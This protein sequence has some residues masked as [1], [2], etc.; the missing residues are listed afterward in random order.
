LYISRLILEVIVQSHDTTYGIGHVV[1]PTSLASPEL[2]KA[3]MTMLDI[4][5]YIP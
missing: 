1:D 3:S 4:G 2:E 5:L